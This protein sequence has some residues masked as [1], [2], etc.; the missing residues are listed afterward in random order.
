[1]RFTQYAGTKWLRTISLTVSLTIWLRC[2]RGKWGQAHVSTGLWKSLE[3]LCAACAFQEALGTDLKVSRMKLA[4]T[5]QR[6]YHIYIFK[7]S[8]VIFN[9]E[10]RRKG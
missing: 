1:M 9:T 3:A 2:V 10:S 4:P 6:L 7:D 8:D 5:F